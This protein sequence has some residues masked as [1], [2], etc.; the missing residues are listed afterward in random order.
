MQ[1]MDMTSSSEVSGSQD[2][3]YWS[4]LA[5]RS[6]LIITCL[7]KWSGRVGLLFI[8]SSTRRADEC[9]CLHACIQI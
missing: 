3:S 1:A 5:E 4:F 7:S 6:N 9:A 8:L 2:E